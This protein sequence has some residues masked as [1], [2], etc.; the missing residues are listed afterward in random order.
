[1]SEKRFVPCFR[2]GKQAVGR[3]SILRGTMEGIPV[4]EEEVADVRTVMQ[5]SNKK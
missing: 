2:R 5:C 1:M 4:R 3:T